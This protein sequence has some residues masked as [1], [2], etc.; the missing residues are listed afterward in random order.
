M[1]LFQLT[2]F[3]EVAHKKALRKRRTPYTSVSR[4]SARE[5]KPW[6]HIGRYSSSTEQ[7]NT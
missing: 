5:L 4:P 6:K 2:Y 3:I 1:D 7:E